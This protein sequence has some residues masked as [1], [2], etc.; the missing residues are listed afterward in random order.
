MLTT[1]ACSFDGRLTLSTSISGSYTAENLARFSIIFTCA[2]STRLLLTC[3]HMCMNEHMCSG[4][5]VGCPLQHIRRQACACSRIQIAFCHLCLFTTN[6]V[7]MP[8]SSYSVHFRWRIVWL[9]IAHNMLPALFAW[10][11]C[12]SQH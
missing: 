12:I 7:S 4:F 11:I 6:I 3:L 5:L 8:T 10:N 1:R 2:V 9:R